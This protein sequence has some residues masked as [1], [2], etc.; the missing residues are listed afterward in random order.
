MKYGNLLKENIDE[1]Y[2][3]YYID[4]NNIKKN[5]NIE[6]EEFIDILK[7]NKTFSSIFIIKNV[8]MIY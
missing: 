6:K 1:K 7:Y 8:K 3:E 2:K 4:Y 5:I